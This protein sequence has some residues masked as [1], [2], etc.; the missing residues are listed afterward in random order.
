MPRKSMLLPLTSIYVTRVHMR[1]HRYRS[2]YRKRLLILHLSL[3]RKW[4]LLVEAWQ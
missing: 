1:I 3:H 4:Q 2:C